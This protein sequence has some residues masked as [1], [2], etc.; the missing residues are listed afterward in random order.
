M[1]DL[2][3]IFSCN[4]GRVHIRGGLG[5]CKPSQGFAFDFYAI[6]TFNLL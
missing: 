2:K 5:G 1:T 4:S 6:F 3:Q